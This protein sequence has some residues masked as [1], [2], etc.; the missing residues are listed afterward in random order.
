MVQLVFGFMPYVKKEFLELNSEKP[1]YCFV[2][3]TNYNISRKFEFSTVVYCKIVKR[4]EIEL[5]SKVFMFG[6]K[7]K[8]KLVR[9]LFTKT[10]T[11][12]YL[13]RSF[14]ALIPYN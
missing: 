11:C 9:K 6:G 1:F 8:A 4:S 3:G 2:Y 7:K 12:I 10:A 5:N 13:V 14:N